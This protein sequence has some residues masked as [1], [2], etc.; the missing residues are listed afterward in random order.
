MCPGGYALINNWFIFLMYS[1]T[2]KS[3]PRSFNNIFDTSLPVRYILGMNPASCIVVPVL[4]ICEH[5]FAC[6]LPFMQ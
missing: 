4:A 1:L 5:I 3:L 6:F 2:P